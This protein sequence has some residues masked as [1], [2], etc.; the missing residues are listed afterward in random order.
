MQF[1]SISI[2]VSE[3]EPVCH[4][5]LSILDL[6]LFLT[7]SLQVLCVWPPKYLHM[8]IFSSLLKLYFFQEFCFDLLCLV[9]LKVSTHSTEVHYAFPP[10]FLLSMSSL[11]RQAESALC[12]TQLC[13]FTIAADLAQHTFG[14]MGMEI[15]PT[16]LPRFR[17]C[18]FPFEMESPLR[19]F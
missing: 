5:E 4:F 11:P 14:E 8:F 9:I 1:S 10:P 18:D 15:V 19:G 3:S 12:Q 13:L 2:S 17:V 6:S 16:V 7:T